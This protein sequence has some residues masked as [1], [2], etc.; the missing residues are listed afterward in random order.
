MV[1]V[2]GGGTGTSTRAGRGANIARQRGAAGARGTRL[3][4]S[5]STRAS[6]ATR[7]GRRLIADEVASRG[8][9][10]AVYNITDIGLKE[11]AE[12]DVVFI[13]TWVDG[14]V[15]FGHRPGAGRIK[16]M[17]V[18][19]GKQVAAFMTYAI[20]AGKAL[21]RFSRVLTERGAVVVARGCCAATGSTRASRS[22]SPR[23]WPPSPPERPVR[24]T[25]RRNILWVLALVVALAVGVAFVREDGATPR[26]WCRPRAHGARRPG[27]GVGRPRPP[28]PPTCAS[29]GRWRG[30]EAGAP[31]AVPLP[32]PATVRVALTEPTVAPHRCWW[33]RPPTSSRPR[34]SRSRSCR[35]TSPRPTRPWP[36]ARSTRWSAP[37][38]PLPRRGAGRQRRPPGA[39]RPL[40]RAP[41]DT[42]VAQAGLWARNDVLP[43]PDE[44]RSVEGQL[45]AVSGGMGSARCTR[46]AWCS[47]RTS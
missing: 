19:D 34:T 36:G 37:W 17:P 15:L 42:D 24:S 16:R 14:L 20:H 25:T 22:W 28:I 26:W 23:R 44:W 46:S 8:V 3:E 11:L 27:R 12:A 38:T 41:N 4:R 21:D 7:P 47:T 35:W 10:V 9:E 1:T 30:C 32:Q 33:P 13:G 6:P 31:E 39:G 2:V 5:S 45:M 29:A 18:V 40:S 43:D